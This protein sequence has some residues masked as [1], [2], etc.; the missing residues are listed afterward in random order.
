[1]LKYRGKGL[2]RSGFIGAVLIVLVI[3]IGLNSEKLISLATSVRHR[4]IFAEAGGLSSGNTVLVSG[5]K[6]G[7]VS[8][9]SLEDG[10]AL[11]TFVVDGKA[12]LGSE[13]TAHIRTGT[14]LGQRVLTLESAG[15]GRL[16]STDVIPVSRTSSPYSLTEATNELT[17]NVAGTDTDALN[18]SL[19]A[20]SDT[21]DQIAPQ[22]GPSFEG[23]SRMSK[24]LN[25]RNQSLG[26]L[27]KNATDL[28]EI[29]S[30]RGEQVNTLILNANDLLSVLV[31]QRQAIVELLAN[32][33]TVAKA[34]SGVIHDNEPKLA[35]T[36]QKLNSVTAM[37][38]KNRDNIAKAIPGLAKFEI[39]LG[40]AL[41]SG[42]YYQG[43]IANAL[44]SQLLQPF[45]DYA[46]GFRRGT[47]AGQPP[48][49]AGPRAELPFP[50][51]GIPGPGE[52][53][54]PPR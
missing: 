33:S 14:V 9:V 2:I 23:L 24:A 37:L 46:F 16:R 48:D 6:V 30:K 8:D 38:E 4:A 20:L 28:T 29:L 7:T 5:M 3:V 10:E 42:F 31:A 47:D 52:Q 26:D 54:G 45:L 41:S 11:V 17:E 39:T 13:T 21:I 22:L 32:V 34:V 15:Q 53:W 27:L 25:E 19:D 40:E 18:R 35:P 36:L 50:Y 43:F 49:N 12:N 1:M 51:N 44:P